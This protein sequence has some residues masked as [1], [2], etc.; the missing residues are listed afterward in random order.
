MLHHYLEATIGYKTMHMFGICDVQEITTKAFQHITAPC[1]L[2]N[3]CSLVMIKHM[4]TVE[5]RY[6]KL[7]YVQ[8]CETRSVYLN[9]KVHLIAFSNHNLALETFLQVQIT[10]SAN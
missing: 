2:L 3:Y 7:G 5:S 8:L 6:L 9:K 1:H 10:R 4:Y